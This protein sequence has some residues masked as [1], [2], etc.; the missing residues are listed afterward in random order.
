ML[1]SPDANVT[2]VAAAVEGEEGEGGKRGLFGPQCAKS[3]CLRDD[4]LVVGVTTAKQTDIT[5]TLSVFRG[6]APL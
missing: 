5:S 2:A 1:I 6:D 3:R 4:A